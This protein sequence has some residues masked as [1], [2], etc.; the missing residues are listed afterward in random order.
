MRRR[1][2]L[3]VLPGLAVVVGVGTVVPG[4]R[5]D[6]ITRQ[7]FARIE[8]GMSPTEVEAILGPPGDYRTGPANGLGVFECAGGEVVARLDEHRAMYF[9]I[10]DTTC[11]DVV[12]DDAIG[13][14]S[15]RYCASVDRV[16]QSAFDNLLW[17]AKRLWHRWF[18]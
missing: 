3:V 1:T 10:S 12:F 16:P 11:I 5:R 6:R 8:D 13:A 14:A 2:L 9:W 4:L 17:R 7:N 18:P 15:H